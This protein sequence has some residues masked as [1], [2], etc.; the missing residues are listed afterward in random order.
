MVLTNGIWTRMRLVNSNMRY[1]KQV[2]NRMEY[3]TADYGYPKIKS[4]HPWETRVNQSS[5]NVA[6]TCKI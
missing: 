3:V 5:C 2:L 6:Y 1:K 4:F